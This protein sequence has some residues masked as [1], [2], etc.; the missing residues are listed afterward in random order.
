MLE[1]AVQVRRTVGTPPPDIEAEVVSTSRLLSIKRS[2]HGYASIA[3]SP[4]LR[5]AKELAQRADRADIHARLL[6]AE[7]AAYD[8][9]CDFDRSDAIAQQLHELGARGDEPLARITGLASLGI[10]RWHRGHVGEASALLDDACRA[11]ADAAVPT[12][13]LGLDL[14]VVLLPYPFARYLHVLTGDLDEVA[15]EAEFE[16]L[17]AAAPDRYAVS[18]VQMFASAGAVTTGRAEWAE[19]AARRGI[20]ADPE[21]TFSFWGR[22]LHG[23]LAAALVLQ[24]RVDEGLSMIDAAIDHFIE[25]GGRTGVVVYK[26]ARAAGL[27]AAGRIDAAVDAVA[28]AYRELEVYGERFAEPLVLEA[29]A[30]LRHARSDDPAEVAGVMTAAIA[31]AAEQGSHA[32]ARRIAATAQRLGMSTG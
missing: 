10:S 29:D 32:I 11:A 20:D 26:A 18:L 6:W 5:R 31:L 23:Y 13:T 9:R 4:H 24:G 22:G 16:A 27:A 17:A 25:A 28:A 1:R 15:G 2:V 21:G 19:R 30:S 12:A 7:W 3:D 14:E 8:T